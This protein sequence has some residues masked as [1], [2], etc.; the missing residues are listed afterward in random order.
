LVA[1]DGVDFAVE[2][3]EIVGL[4]GPN[5]AGKTTL[6]NLVS[7][8]L[9]MD[10][11]EMLMKGHPIGELPPHERS[12]LGIARTFQLV[13]P[14][15]GLTV[16]QNIL[17]GALFG[18]GGRR[19]RKKQG[20]LDETNRVLNLVG[21]HDKADRI[22]EQL[23]VQDKKRIELARA[24]AT[25]P[26]VL[27]LDEVMSGL[28]PAEVDEMSGLVQQVNKSGVAVIMIEHVMRA[29]MRISGRVIVLQ[30]GRKIAD[31]SPESVRNDETVVKAYLGQRFRA[32]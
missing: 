13:K 24:L 4:I 9:R 26:E 32:T 8:L 14:F 11:G 15:R 6:A 23:T 18:R 7:G 16:R 21:L 25:H 30:N 31:G 2:D 12:R 20:A 5:G 1:V 29:V 27:L 28:T 10:A 22:A 17:V 19:H 3:G